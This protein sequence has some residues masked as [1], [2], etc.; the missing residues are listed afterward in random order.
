MGR[1]AFRSVTMLI[2]NTLKVLLHP[3]TYSVETT[4][5]ALSMTYRSSVVSTGTRLRPRQWRVRISAGTWKF[6]LPKT[7]IWFPPTLSLNRYRAY[8]L[9]LKRL[10]S[11]VNHS[12]APGDVLKNEWSYTS[13]LHTCLHDVQEKPLPL[14]YHYINWA[15]KPTLKYSMT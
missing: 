4:F 8:F 13:T 6:S 10:W 3:T 9:A 12:P 14:P 7:W 2:P 5:L 11:L 15:L 1:Q